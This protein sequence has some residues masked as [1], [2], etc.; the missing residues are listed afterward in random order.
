VEDTPGVTNAPDTNAVT[1]DD[2]FT[3]GVT[4]VRRNE[5]VIFGHDYELKEGDSAEEVVVFGGHA[6]IRGKVRGEVVTIGGDIKIEGGQVGGEAV[7]VLGG[8]HLG[9]GASVRHDVVA[10]GGQVTKA[11]G[12]KIGGQT[13]EVDFSEIGLPHVN[14]L[15]QYFVQC[16]MKLRPLAPSVGW[17]WAVAAVFFLIYLL[18]AVAFQRPV[19]ACINELTR[20]PATTF[21]VG[22]LSNLL[23]PFLM[24]ILSVTIIGVPFIMLAAFLG[25]I[26]GK[27]ALMQLLGSRVGGRFGAVPLQSPL[28]GFAIG[29]GIIILLY[30]IP[31]V[32][33]LTLGV[34]SVWGFGGAVSAIFA[35]LRKEMPKPAMA[36]AGAG[37]PAMATAGAGAMAEAEGASSSG[38]TGDPALGSAGPAGAGMPASPRLPEVV[39]FPKAGF[40]ERMAAGF[41]DL[42]IVGFLAGLL[43][44]APL[45]F[46]MTLAY[47]AAMWTWRGTTVGG[48]VLGLKVVRFDG[49]HLTFIVALVRALAAGFSVAVLFLGFLW[50]AWSRD[51]QGWHDKI[52][53]TVVI[54]V[55]RSTPLVVY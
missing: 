17:I 32:G 50:I 11:D 14:W 53:G 40:W 31:I 1:D 8:I 47:F 13:Q 22:L 21:F 54:R 33:L 48:I 27:A 3:K 19:Q 5:V 36:V 29:A 15:R 44:F 37:V 7:A 18:V 23:L 51:K 2:D 10:V 26:I 24:A 34:T 25:A 46:L 43:H 55:P 9:P 52:A 39:E 28:I 41:L 6:T 38:I 42:L 45:G 20:R 4:G 35:G 30:Q 12:A 16:V 49:Q